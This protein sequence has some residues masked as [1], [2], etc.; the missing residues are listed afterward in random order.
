MRKLDGLVAALN[1]KVWNFSTC[2]HITPS[3]IGYVCTVVPFNVS[4]KRYKSQMYDLQ[5][6]GGSS[7]WC[8]KA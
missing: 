6:V 4:V 1:D 2:A 3:L 7:N 8:L 5:L